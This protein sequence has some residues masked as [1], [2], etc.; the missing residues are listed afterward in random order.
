ME[1]QKILN[2]LNEESN[3]KIETRKWN[4]VN[5]QSNANYDA[6][7]KII[8]KIEALKSNLSGFNDAYILLRGDITIMGH[9][10]IQVAFKNCAPSTKQI[11]KIDG[12]LDYAEDLDLLM[13]KY[14]LIERS[15]KYSEKTKSLWFY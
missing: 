7:N 14:N 11:I 9:P 12:T 13:P 6:G 1:Q 4:I 10:V 3:S 5:A 15:S 8:Y 2:L